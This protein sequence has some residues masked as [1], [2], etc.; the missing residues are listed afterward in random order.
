MVKGLLCKVNG[1]SDG[2]K[3]GEEKS[4]EEK[5]RVDCFV[6]GLGG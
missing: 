3:R 6:F 5:G 4:R 2:N 1:G